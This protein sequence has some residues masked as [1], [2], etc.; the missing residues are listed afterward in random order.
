MNKVLVVEDDVVSRRLLGFH[1]RRAGFDVVEAH[2]AVMARLV[3][4]HEAPDMIL[5]DLSM[6]YGDGFDLAAGLKDFPGLEE[7][8]FAFVSGHGSTAHRD[9]ALQL[10]AVAFLQKPVAPHE[11]VATVRNSLRQPALA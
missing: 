2:D 7:T 11:L 8:P 10:G 3:T 4:L 1:L 5:F 9:R 6:P